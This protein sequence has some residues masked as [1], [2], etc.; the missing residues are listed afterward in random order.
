MFRV[1]CPRKFGTIHSGGKVIEK[2]KKFFEI[3]CVLALVVSVVTGCSCSSKQEV[4]T[5]E[6]KPATVD[7]ANDE[8]KLI[9][10]EFTLSTDYNYYIGEKDMYSTLT[11]V[12][13]KY[14]YSNKTGIYV[15]TDLKKDGKKISKNHPRTA[16]SNGAVL[17]DGKTVYYLSVKEGSD[18]KYEYSV[19]SVNIDGK[20]EKN[21]LSGVG[22]AS[23]IT[24]YKG[25]LYFRNSPDTSAEKDTSIM[26]YK[27]GSKKDPE[28]I[29]LDYQAN[30]NCVYNGKIYFSNDKFS[31]P[32][33]VKD[34]SIKYDVY[35][36]DLETNDINKAVEYSYGESI[37]AYDSGDAAF[38][39]R[40]EG[41]K[42]KICIIDKDGKTTESKKFKAKM[43]PWFVDK[44]SENAVMVDFNR[45]DHEVFYTYNIKTAKNY[46]IGV[47]PKNF[48][49]EKVTSG[50]KP[51]KTPYI[52]LSSE[53]KKYYSK[54]SVLM[55]NG[56]K[57]KFCKIKGKKSVEADTFWIS[58]NKLITEVN[59]KMKVYKLK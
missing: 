45:P 21:I 50:L 16:W 26:R 59:N 15:K 38:Y 54:I 14:I 19:Y 43:D 6:T 11:Y 17:S 13:G 5:E 48:S 1:F 52:V 4:K 36:L 51:S 31:S 35:S 7:E 32:D 56:K 46:K 22:P 58:D 44:N 27:L 57:A 10:N 30:Y 29:S 9:K 33:I 3:I 49:C 47:S 42:G 55:V 37:A 20:G 53:G 39:S 2:M 12:K 28:M 34:K 40:R 8:N 18:S 25:N 41:E 24:V 23:L